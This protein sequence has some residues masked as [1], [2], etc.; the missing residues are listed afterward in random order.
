MFS[1]MGFS[2]EDYNISGGYVNFRTVYFAI[3]N[4]KLSQFSVVAPVAGPAVRS[5][6]K[7]VVAA[8]AAPVFEPAAPMAPRSKLL[9]ELL[10]IAGF[11]ALIIFR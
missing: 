6:I 4:K 7:P 3:E 8:V 5:A 10:G 11:C 2:P 9:E 1:A